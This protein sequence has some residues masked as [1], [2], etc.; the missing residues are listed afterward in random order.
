MASRDIIC[1]IPTTTTLAYIA[2]RGLRSTSET[3]RARTT[4]LTSTPTSSK[5]IPRP[6]MMWWKI[7]LGQRCSRAQQ[8]DAEESSSLRVKASSST[9]W[10]SKLSMMKTKKVYPEP[11]ISLRNTWVPVRD[12]PARTTVSKSSVDLLSS[13]VMS[14]GRLLGRSISLFLRSLTQSRK[15][16]RCTRRAKGKKVKRGVSL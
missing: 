12:L 15:L 9:A 13:L 6:S 1:Q 16:S 10:V 5:A 7:G 4:S 3:S 14:H 2:L 11:N 8:A